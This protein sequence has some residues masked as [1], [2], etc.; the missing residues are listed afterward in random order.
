MRLNSKGG[1]SVREHLLDGISMIWPRGH[2]IP[3]RV[4]KRVFLSMDFWPFFDVFLGEKCFMRVKNERF[5]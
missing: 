2:V 5:A 3:A 1:V 4:K